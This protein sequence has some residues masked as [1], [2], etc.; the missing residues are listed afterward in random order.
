MKETTTSLKYGNAQTVAELIRIQVDLTVQR[1]ALVS[2]RRIEMTQAN[3]FG[4]TVKVPT[5]SMSAPDWKGEKTATKQ[6]P[7]GQPRD[8]QGNYMSDDDIQYPKEYCINQI[9][10]EGYLWDM[11][12]W[13]KYKDKAEVMERLNNLRDLNCGHTVFCIKLLLNRYNVSK[14]EV[15][16]VIMRNSNRK[17]KNRLVKCFGDAGKCPKYLKQGDY[18]GGICKRCE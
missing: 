4:E 12:C 10:S 17:Y 3:L 9:E 16:G 15:C 5:V 18:S 8:E 14:E 2:S 11:R 7:L 6:V 13:N 1:V